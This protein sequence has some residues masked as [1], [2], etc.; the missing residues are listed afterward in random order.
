M[1]SCSYKEPFFRLFFIIG[2]LKRRLRRRCCINLITFYNKK[3]SYAPTLR[4]TTR[5]EERLSK[6][7]G[8]IIQKLARDSIGNLL[9]DFLAMFL[10][11]CHT[12]AVFAVSGNT[13]DRLIY[14]SAGQSGAPEDRDCIRE[15][16]IT[17]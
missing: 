4:E 14:S 10:P 11:Y 6:G 13:R 5:I 2:S 17:K 3:K 16:P 15:N 7:G 9:R 8:I 12:S 1:C